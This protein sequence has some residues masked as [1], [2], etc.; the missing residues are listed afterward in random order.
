[1][2]EIND[3]TGIIVSAHK[4]HDKHKYIIVEANFRSS[5]RASKCLPKLIKVD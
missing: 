4:N 2:F 1:M 5:F 3:N